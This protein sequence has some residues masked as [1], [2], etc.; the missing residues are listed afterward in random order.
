MTGAI[1]LAGGRA[2]RVGGAD[3]TLFEVAGT[4]LLQRAV[5]AVAC[6]DPITVVGDPVPGVT[7]VAGVAWAR[8]DPPFGGPAAA[9]VAALATWRDDPEWTYLL[10]CDLPEAVAAA[11]RLADARPLLPRETDGVCLSAADS[12]P[13]WLIGLYR[14]AALRRGA[15]A[16]PNKGQDASMRA[17]LDDAAIAVIAAPGPETQDVDTWEDLSEARARLEETR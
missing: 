12:R 1:L 10:A 3:K 2:S 13:Q 15:D 16:L 4:T 5:D 8:E 11:S 17:L 6:A 7:A 9:V 14:T